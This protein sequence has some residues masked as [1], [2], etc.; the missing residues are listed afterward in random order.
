[1]PQ[2]AAGIENTDDHARVT[3]IDVP[4]RVTGSSSTDPPH[5][6]LI[7]EVRVI[8]DVGQGYEHRHGFELDVAH[9]LVALLKEPG[10]QLDRGFFERTLDAKITVLAQVLRKLGVLLQT[11]PIDQF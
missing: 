4:C 7:R 3:P 10:A 11:M 1:M 8:G 6:P 9:N 5:V 2:V